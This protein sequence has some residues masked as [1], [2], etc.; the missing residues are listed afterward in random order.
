MRDVITWGVPLQNIIIS[1]Q[2]NSNPTPWYQFEK[3]GNNT[4]FTRYQNHLKE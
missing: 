3:V 4:I 2:M 1:P